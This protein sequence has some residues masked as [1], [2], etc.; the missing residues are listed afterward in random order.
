M[1]KSL[2]TK[3]SLAAV[4]AKKDKSVKLSK[5]VVVEKTPKKKRSKLTRWFRSRFRSWVLYLKFYFSKF[6]KLTLRKTKVKI[7]RVLFGLTI[8]YFI[9]GV[10]LGTGFYMKEYKLCTDK[11]LFC[12]ISLDSKFALFWTTV[13]PF[14][15]EIVGNQVVTLH[16]VAEQEKIIYYFAEQSSSEIPSASEVDAQVMD[17]IEEIKL[18]KKI[19]AQNNIKLTNDEVDSVFSQIEEENGGKEEVQNLL[20]TLYGITSAEFRK[21]VKEQLYQ[22]KV[23]TEILKTIKVRHILVADE[24]KA[25]EV[26]AKIDSGEMTYEDAAAQYSTDE[27][28]RENGGLITVDTSSDYISRDSGFVD[29]FTNAA[30]SLETGVVSDPVQTEY[31]FHLIRVDDIKGT[32][33]M[34]YTD[35]IQD[36]KNNTIIWRLYR[37]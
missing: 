1:E 27:V 5:K 30:F 33:D 18:S 29:E 32:V 31:G 37:R 7:A 6:K 13:Y 9:G 21:V 12:P 14:P 22:D 20:S 35:Y 25:L 19:L 16:E 8:A 23:R 24:A 11:Q 10:V 4:K 2:Q 36:I 17:S 3:K 34:T 28:T 15:A 26:K